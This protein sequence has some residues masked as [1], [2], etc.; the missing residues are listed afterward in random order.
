MQL[1]GWTYGVM[2][3]TR[4]GV[5]YKANDAYTVKTLW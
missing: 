2:G 5:I 1:D 4:T 3:E